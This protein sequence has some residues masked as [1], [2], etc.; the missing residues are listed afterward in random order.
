[1][2]QFVSYQKTLIYSLGKKNDKSEIS[3]LKKQIN[4]LNSRVADYE[5]LK[6]DN[7]AL[8]SQFESS[9]EESQALVG[10]SILGFT[11]DNNFPDTLVINVGEKE[12]IRMGMA[13]VF[14]KYLV[15]KISKVSKNFSVVETVLN[16]RF[17]T[18]AKVPSKNANGIIVGT[19]EFMLLDKVVI[20]DEIE[21]DANV[22]TRGEVSSSG[23][24]IYPDI[25]IGKITNV[26]KNEAAPFQSARV[27]PVIDF[28]RLTKVFVVESM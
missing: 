27:E 4:E 22:V 21:K 13:V 19:R 12:N 8:R 9:G 1:M 3:K 23:I 2:Q 11:G 17:K 20:T 15:G 14:Q 24:G 16:P 18:L 7:D 6:R 5:L 25:I 26:S 10:A 28:S